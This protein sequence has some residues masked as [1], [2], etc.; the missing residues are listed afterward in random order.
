MCSS[1]KSVDNSLQEPTQKDFQ[2]ETWQEASWLLQSSP[3]HPLDMFI[4]K[5]ILFCNKG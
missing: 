3:L 5:V 1:Q 2:L 4:T